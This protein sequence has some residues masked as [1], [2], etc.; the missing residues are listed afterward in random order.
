M[1]RETLDL[2]GSGLLLA[3][4]VTATFAVL[5]P[6][7]GASTASSPPPSDG[8]LVGSSTASER[9]LALFYAKGCVTCHRIAGVEGGHEVGPDLTGL[10]A[11]AGTTRP[12][13]S[14]EAYIEESL[15]TPSAFLAA[16]SISGG[17]LA[18]PDL[19]LSNDEIADLTAFLLGTPGSP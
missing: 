2:I 6:T 17:N 15:R 9:G 14:A 18:M 12:G 1:R 7:P 4:L 5:A 8:A 16:S 11:R 3:A 10:A 13:M 19:G